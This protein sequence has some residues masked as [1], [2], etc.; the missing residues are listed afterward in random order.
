MGEDFR[1]V[2]L[3]AAATGAIAEMREAGVFSERRARLERER[4]REAE[5]VVRAETEG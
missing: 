2:P 1:Q 4:E 3:T 5:A